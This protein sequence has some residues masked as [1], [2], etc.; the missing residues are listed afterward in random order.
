MRLWSPRKA[1][2]RWPRGDQVRSGGERAA[3]VVAE[4]AVGVDE[5]RRAVDEHEPDA[6]VMVG[7]EVGVVRPRGNDDQPV[8]AA[9]EERLGE[10]ALACRVLIRAAD[11][12]QDA[13]RARHRLD[14]TQQRRV[15]RVRD[16]V[17]HDP[18]AGRRA[19]R[20]PQVRRRQVAPVAEQRHRLVHLVGQIR[21]HGALRVDDA[22]HRGQAH[23]GQRRDFLH[24]RS[25]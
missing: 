25:P 18:D 8:H 19:I 4:H 11:Q 16:V 17:E 12:R 9:G 24:G 5:R 20:P 6:G 13:A 22:R 3:R 23:A 7:A 1:I 10:L 2:R 21:P 15:E 14:A